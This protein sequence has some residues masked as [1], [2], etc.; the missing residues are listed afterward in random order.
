MKAPLP[1]D[2]GYK[3]DKL[4]I[5]YFSRKIKVKLL[6]VYSSLLRKNYFR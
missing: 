6:H 1:L 3:F 5:K 4:V 2:D